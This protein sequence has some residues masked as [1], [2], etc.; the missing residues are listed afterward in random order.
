VIKEA[1]A[2]KYLRHLRDAGYLIQVKGSRSCAVM[3]RFL[4]SM[5]T[6]PRAPMI[7]RVK[8]VWDQNLKK[9]MWSEESTGSLTAEED[10]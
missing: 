7:Q 9:V 3:W 6:G 2:E 5:H 10:L 4:P 1:T 8:R